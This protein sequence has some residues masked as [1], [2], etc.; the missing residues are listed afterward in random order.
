[1]KNNGSKNIPVFFV[2]LT[3]DKLGKESKCKVHPRTSHEGPEGGIGIVI[4][5]L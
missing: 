3:I 2:C 1:M 4:L 5:F